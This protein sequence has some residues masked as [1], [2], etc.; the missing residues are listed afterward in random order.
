[1]SIHKSAASSRRFAG[2]RAPGSNG[3]TRDYA[4]QH[5]ELGEKRA[6]VKFARAEK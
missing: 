6:L 3:K 5:V 4:S 1:M 2:D